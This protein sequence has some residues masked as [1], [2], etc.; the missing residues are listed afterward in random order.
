ML[1]MKIPYCVI[2]TLNIIVITI[3]L[4]S[5]GQDR[6]KIDYKTKI[7]TTSVIDYQIADTT[8]MLVS[9][10][11][12]KFDST[13]VVLSAIGLVDLQARDGY[14]K[15]GLKRSQPTAK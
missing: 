9:E 3:Q 15:M 5:C 2:R 13:D 6:P 14:I 1:S 8:K 10:L 12:I 4:F 11:P 7:D